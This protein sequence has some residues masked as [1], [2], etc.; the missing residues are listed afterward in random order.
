MLN[1]ILTTAET[2]ELLKVDEQT[3]RRWAKVGRI[4]ALKLPGGRDWRFEKT[5]IML[6]MQGEGNHANGREKAPP[7]GE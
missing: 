6:W 4:P 7:T 3:V 1:E 5:N 2:A